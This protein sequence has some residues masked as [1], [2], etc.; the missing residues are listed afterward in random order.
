MLLKN[1]K[2]NEKNNIYH[3]M[4]LANTSSVLLVDGYMI[5]GKILYASQNFAFLFMYNSKELL[6]ITIDDL[7][8]SVIQ[9][10]HKELVNDAIKY[11]NISYIFKAPKESL[12]KNK[13][14]GLFNIKLFVKP[15]PNLNF[16]L[17]YYSFIQKINDSKFVI[18]L[19]KDLKIS[20]Y[21]EQSQ[22]GSSFTIGNG[23]NI[24]PSI[25]GYNIGLVIP[26]ILP[27]IEYKMMNLILIKKIMN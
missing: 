11:S 22:T 23:F 21:T 26:D 8:P 19:N 7:M 1:K 25:I 4:F 6:N 15:A 24:T 12:L 3:S 9:N 27:L 14:G 20:G 17:I 5:N 13:N 10:F 16:G 2:L 18:I